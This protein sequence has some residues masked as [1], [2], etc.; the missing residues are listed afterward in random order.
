MK[1]KLLF[2]YV[3]PSLN[4]RQIVSNLFFFPRH[5]I[6]LA[7]CSIP[8]IA[9]TTP[10]P[11]ALLVALGQPQ[12]VPQEQAPPSALVLPTAQQVSS[13]IKTIDFLYL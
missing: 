13:D 10:P 3:N 7:L 9:N 8:S 2:L 12:Q 6:F 4:E 5:F 11:Q 1:M